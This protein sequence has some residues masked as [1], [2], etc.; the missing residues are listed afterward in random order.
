MRHVIAGALA[1]FPIA[2]RSV[3]PEGQFL[4]P[5]LHVWFESLQQPGTAKPCCGI[6]NC[7]FTDFKMLSDGHYQIDI[8]GWDYVV[9]NETVIAN[10]G[11]PTGKAVVCYDYLDFGP[12]VPQGTTRTAP[13]DTIAVVCFTPPT[14]IM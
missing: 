12:S 1:L 8:D 5:A 11:N 9:P 14:T 13:Q 10:S 2:A 3:P 4:N 6:A 7:H